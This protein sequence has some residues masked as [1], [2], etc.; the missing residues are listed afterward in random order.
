[1]SNET[2][3]VLVFGA[4]GE[5][6]GRIARQCVDAGHRVTGVTRGKNTRPHVSLD[7][8]ELITGDKGDGDFLARLAVENT[9][10]VVVDSVPGTEHVK[11][12]FEHFNGKIGLYLMCGSTGTFVPL[13][14]LPADENHPWREETYCN[15]YD[16]CV[17]DAYALSLW[18]EHGFPVTI[19]R[20]TNIIGRGRIPLDLWGGRN[21]RYWQRV[22]AGE[23]VEVPLS[24]NVLVQSGCN[25]DLASAFVK[26]AS[27][28]QEIAGEVFIISS[29]KAITHDQYLAAAKDVLK[30]DSPV[31][32]LAAQEILKRHPQDVD[33][34]G[35]GF[36]VEH[37][38]FDIGKAETILGYC[39]R[40]SPEQG[41]TQALAWCMEEGLLA[42][43]RGE[44]SG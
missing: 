22:K 23:P 1:M 7:G 29:K 15:F 27:K 25:D 30:S 5:I 40:Y 12:A 34:D 17:R 41:L 10:D 2:K 9:F 8:V 42:P 39:P 19:L 13:Q 14:Y 37:M 26:A 3:N 35:L 32:H 33:A 21:I 24:G 4:T 28:G 38:C 36:L 11:L 43:E 44:G 20:P 31:E 16:Q 6:G 18:E